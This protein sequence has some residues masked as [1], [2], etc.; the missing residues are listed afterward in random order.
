MYNSKTIILAKLPPGIRWAW[1]KKQ[2]DYFTISGKRINRGKNVKT[3]GIAN[4][5]QIINNILYKLILL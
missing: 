1:G 5:N 3:K 2:I 4:I